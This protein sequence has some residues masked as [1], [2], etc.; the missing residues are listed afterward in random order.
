MYVVDCFVNRQYS[1]EWISYLP[2]H[3]IIQAMGSS[4]ERQEDKGAWKEKRICIET[5]DSMTFKTK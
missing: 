3:F 1:S 5:N 4:K 2:S